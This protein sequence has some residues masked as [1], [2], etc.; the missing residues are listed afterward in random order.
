[1]PGQGLAA[2]FAMFFGAEVAADISGMKLMISDL[3]PE[4]T[5][6]RRTFKCAYT[7]ENAAQQCDG[8]YFPSTVKTRRVSMTKVGEGVWAFLDFFKLH[9]C[10]EGGTCESATLPAS[11]Q[12]RMQTKI[13]VHSQTGDWYIAYRCGTIRCPKDSSALGVD[14]E[15]CEHFWSSG[16]SGSNCTLNDYGSWYV[17][18]NANGDILATSKTNTQI[19]KCPKDTL[20][21][22]AMTLNLPDSLNNPRQITIDPSGNMIIADTNNR[23]VVRCASDGSSCEVVVD[24]AVHS[25]DLNLVPLKAYARPDEPDT[26]VLSLDL[27]YTI[28]ECP[29]GTTHHDECRVVVGE[30]GNRVEQAEMEI[31]SQSGSPQILG[32]IWDFYLDAPAV[33][34]SPSGCGACAGLTLTD[35]PVVGCSSQDPGEKSCEDF[36]TKVQEN[37][38]KY[39]QCGTSRSQCLTKGPPLN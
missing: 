27:G 36:Y 7:A 12:S 3:G 6:D 9:R 18:E 21:C 17:G 8:D 26:F 4:G 24:L 33:S 32:G 2:M 29:K 16:P 37:P 23:R 31:P 19:F 35:K 15:N 25:Q 5:Q 39:F 22:S 34:S 20:Q 28:S 13:H 11:L 14:I 30:L 38:D 1:M 10:T